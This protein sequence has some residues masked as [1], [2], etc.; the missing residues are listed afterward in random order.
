MGIL[1][2]G[3]LWRK[4]IDLQIF[5]DN[6]RYVFFN[7]FVTINVFNVLGEEVVTLL[8]GE[9]AAGNFKAVWDASG[10]PSGV[11]IYR[12]QADDFVATRKRVLVR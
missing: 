5:S 2:T 10:L 12:I 8:A 11:Y 4:R 3:S 9:R 6:F 7:A 1:A